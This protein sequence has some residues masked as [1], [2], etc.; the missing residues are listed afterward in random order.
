MRIGVQINFQTISSF[1]YLLRTVLFILFLPLVV[2]SGARYLTSPGFT[3]FCWGFALGDLCGTYQLFPVF[4][5]VVV[6]VCFWFHDFSL[7]L[8]Q[9]AQVLCLKPKIGKYLLIRLKNLHFPGLWVWA[10]RVTVVFRQFLCEEWLWISFLFFCRPYL[11]VWPFDLGE[12][13]VSRHDTSALTI[14]RLWKP[15]RRV[16]RLPESPL[17]N[18]TAC[19]APVVAFWHLA[20]KSFSC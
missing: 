9:K 6:V 19:D 4:S 2:L 20:G 12:N 3:F 18:Q 16:P 13:T 15:H 5:L 8:L 14:G 17:M 1:F 10:Q 7:S 11:D